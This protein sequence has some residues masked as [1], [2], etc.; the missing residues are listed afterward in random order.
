M[1]FNAF[2]VPLLLTIII[3]T[4]VAILLGN[5]RM[6]F[7]TAFVCVNIMTNPLLNYVI[8]VLKYFKAYNILIL[9][10]MEIIVVICEWKAL[11]Y[12]FRKRDKSL[13][14]LSILSNAASFG[15]GLTLFIENIV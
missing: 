4:L 8:M 5:R 6:G 11:S 15:V 7:L 9:V 3:E 2:L 13:L 10:I 12:A 1:V 14:K